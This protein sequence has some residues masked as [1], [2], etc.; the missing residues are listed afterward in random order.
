MHSGRIPSKIAL[1]C[2]SNSSCYCSTATS[3]YASHLLL[4]LSSGFH[5]APRQA[6]EL[7]SEI[8][9]IETVNT[10]H[11]QSIELVAY[12]KKNYI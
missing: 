11:L 12:S 8:M 10:F 3:G 4:L 9:A 6:D 1:S 7:S 2:D 5:N